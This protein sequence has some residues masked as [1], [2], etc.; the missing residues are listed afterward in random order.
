MIERTLGQ[1]KL[2]GPAVAVGPS[3]PRSDGKAA[4]FQA[5]LSR[6]DANVQSARVDSH[7]PAADVVARFTPLLLT[8]MFETMLPRGKSVMGE[9]LAGDV[10]RSFL[11]QELGSLLARQMAAQP[12][13]PPTGAGR[14]PGDKP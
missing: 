7:L 8:K 12:A 13:V 2:V 3:L 1:A 6:A 5:E 9:G 4:A 14:V 10:W 11:S